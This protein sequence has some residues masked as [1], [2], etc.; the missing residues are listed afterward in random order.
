MSMMRKPIPLKERPVDLIYLAFFILFNILFITYIVDL[1]QVVIRDPFHFRYPVW[2][3]AFMID[4]IHWGREDTRSVA[5][6]PASVLE[7]HDLAGCLIIRTF[8]YCCHLRI[9]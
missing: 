2:P 3:P 8:L 6:G 9:Y 1:E 4:M 7:S 5:N